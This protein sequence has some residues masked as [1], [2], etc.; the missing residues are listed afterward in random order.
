MTPIIIRLPKPIPTT[1]T[2]RSN[3]RKREAVSEA[4]ESD[5]VVM[6]E[7]S[8]RAALAGS[9]APVPFTKRA[10]QDGQFGAAGISGPW[11]TTSRQLLQTQ[12]CWITIGGGVVGSIG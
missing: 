10:P 6:V 8:N 3:N 9:G 5:S 12:L 2:I 11:P 4:A 7:A 1:A